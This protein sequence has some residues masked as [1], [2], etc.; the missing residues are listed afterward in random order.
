[1]LSCRS[2]N[3]WRNEDFSPLKK[4]K[5]ER[6]I[7]VFTQTEKPIP[8][9]FEG[10]RRAVFGDPFYPSNLREVQE[11]PIEL[12]YR[13]SL[14][15]SDRVTVAIVGTRRATEEGKK[16]AFR[17]GAQLAQEGVVVVSGL[18]L[19]ID[20]AAHRG[21]LSVEGRTLAVIGTGLNR[22]YPQEHSELAEEIE[23]TGAVISQF[24]PNYTGAKGG[25]NFLKRNHVITGM[26]QVLVAV[27]AGVR[28]GTTAAV[29]AAI[30]QGRPV[31]LLR[32]L[33]QSQ[34]WAQQLIEQGQAFQVESVEDVLRR[35]EF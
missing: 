7:M 22:L 27:E 11:A 4:T 15:S 31:G 25:R 17:L 10:I 32:S 26:S 1:M 24:Q 14:K 6:K 5:K 12:W 19:G 21:A 33:V 13:G 20:G 29:R 35:V 8:S 9:M 16:R 34:Q 23:K 28:S 3:S 2:S 30:G 18:A